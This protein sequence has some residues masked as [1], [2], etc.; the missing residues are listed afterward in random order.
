MQ[1]SSSK[2]IKITFTAQVQTL[3]MKDSLFLQYQSFILNIFEMC[4]D[5]IIKI[6]PFLYLFNSIN[7]EKVFILLKKILLDFEPQINLNVFQ[8]HHLPY[9]L[10]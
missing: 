6:L 7:G 2:A 1:F 8:L 9:F 10:Q 5:A 3:L 4:P